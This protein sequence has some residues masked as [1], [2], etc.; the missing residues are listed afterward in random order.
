MA[1]SLNIKASKAGTVRP[2]APTGPISRDPAPKIGTDTLRTQGASATA[3]A[4]LQ[5]Q[6]VEGLNSLSNGVRQIVLTY[7]IQEGQVDTSKEKQ[8]KQNLTDEIYKLVPGGVYLT[9][10]KG[11]SWSIR[12]LT[13][14]FNILQTMTPGDRKALAGV[15]FIRASHADAVEGASAAVKK[16]YG[17]DASGLLEELGAGGESHAADHEE[18]DKPGFFSRV[19]S[20]IK[21]GFVHAVEAVEGFLNIR[22]LSDKTREAYDGRP[23][24]SIILTDTGS[25]LLVS[26]RIWAHEIGHQLQLSDGRWNPERIREFSRLSGWTE[27]YQD[28]SSEIYDGIDDRTGRRMIFNDKIVK[29]GRTD[30]FVSKYAGTD[31]GEDFAESYSSYLLNPGLLLQKAPE[32]FLFINAE[33]KKYTTEQ[34]TDLAKIAGVDLNRVATDLVKEG[35]LKQETLIDIVSTHDLKP[36][37]AEILG[38]L[39]AKGHKPALMDAWAQIVTHLRANPESADQIVADPSSVIRKDTWDKLIDQDRWVLGNKEFMHKMLGAMGKGMAG[40]KSASAATEL[41]EYRGGTDKILHLLLEDPVF[42]NELVANPANTMVKAGLSGA[43]PADVTQ[44]LC[45]EENREALKNL[46]K[47]LNKMASN[48]QEWEKYQANIRKLSAQMGPD[49]FE[50]FAELLGDRKGTDQAAKVLENAI[51]TG[52]LIFPGDGESQPGP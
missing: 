20:S 3:P 31:P 45:K 29:P 25:N 40:V 33:S 5:N 32:K 4:G 16:Q 42:R 11:A 43:L 27:S 23:Q 9:A 50:A 39:S 28:G 44:A 18:V 34:V 35:S 14:L 19:A 24:R 17:K 2:Q 46:V 47:T 52:N 48:D 13:N 41:E 8:I 38:N 36:N 22:I 12:D 21:S 1:D 6:D 10:G 49:H 30:N 37:Q 7:G 15:N 51:K 26:N